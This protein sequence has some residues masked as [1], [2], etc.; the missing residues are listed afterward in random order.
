MLR[1]FK[2][3]DN[4]DEEQGNDERLTN[5]EMQNKIREVND[6]IT[7]VNNEGWSEYKLPEDASIAQVNILDEDLG[8]LYQK[9]SENRP[10]A[11]EER[12]KI[13]NARQAVMELK[14][15]FKIYDYSEVQNR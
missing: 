1:W 10:H 6:L 7:Q 15:M 13:V 3:D 8:R 12:E 9:V 2:S 11:H 14:H 4:E 5:S